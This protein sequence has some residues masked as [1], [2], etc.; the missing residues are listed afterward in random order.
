MKAKEKIGKGSK[1][2]TLGQKSRK[3]LCMFLYASE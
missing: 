2:M 3:K 1:K